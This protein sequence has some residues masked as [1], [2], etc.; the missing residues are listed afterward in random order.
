MSQEFN[1]IKPESGVTTF[2]QLYQLLRNHFD[3]VR[4][5]FSGTSFPTNPTTGQPCYRTDYNPHRLYI[6]DGTSW[7][8]QS[9]ALNNLQI[10]INEVGNAR[11]SFTNLDD[12]IS[13]IVDDEGNVV[14]TDILEVEQEVQEARGTAIDLDAR[15]GVSLNEDGT[16]KSG[17]TVLNDWWFVEPDGITRLSNNSFYTTGDKRAVYTNNR[18]IKADLDT[19]TK[20]SHVSTA[21]YDNG[22]NTTTVYVFDDILD[23][24]VESIYVGQEVV[25]SPKIEPPEEYLV[26]TGTNV[27]GYITHNQNTLVYPSIDVYTIEDVGPL[28]GEFISN[29]EVSG[30]GGIT[31]RFKSD[32]QWAQIDD[33]NT[34]RIYFGE[35]FNGIVKLS[36]G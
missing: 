26:D 5:N 32:Y 10:V 2:G 31:R 4:S 11:G 13:S 25:N 36:F 1:P 35:V 17:V 18:A 8:D 27:F 20:Y 9:N 16:L 29:T 24:I 34:I 23:S 28:S 14:N 19:T 30:S 6:Y 3:A 12:R 15:L 33:S 21:S 22:S 7:V